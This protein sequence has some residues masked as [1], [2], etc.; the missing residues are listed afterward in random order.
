MLRIWVIR[1]TLLIFIIKVS[2][3]P[4]AIM[5]LYLAVLSTGAQSVTADRNIRYSDGLDEY[6]GVR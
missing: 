1:V 6:K 3:L 4:L 2:L 5:L